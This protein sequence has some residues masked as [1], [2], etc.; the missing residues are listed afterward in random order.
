MKNGFFKKILLG[1]TCLLG[2]LTM[3]SCQSTSTS[4]AKFIKE[5]SNC[6]IIKVGSEG[7]T[8]HVRVSLAVVNNTIYDIK[9]GM[10]S[11]DVTH[12]SGESKTVETVGPYEVDSNF[13][14][15]HGGAGYIVDE[16]VPQDQ[17]KYLDVTNVV[18]SKA[19]VTKLTDVWET[20]MVW[21]ILM[22]VISGISLIS[23]SITIFAKGLSADD[24]A[25]I[26]KQHNASTMITLMFVLIICLFPLM[27]SGWMVTVILLGGFLADI[28]LAGALTAIRTKM[29]ANKT[30]K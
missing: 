15:P 8:I 9:G 1:A 29:L 16:L 19:E 12:G 11:F 28:I 21:W 2:V 25:K 22:I 7:T 13:Y 6:E 26:M 24:L 23:Y 27:F 18:F 4:E 17:E 5:Q 14:I 20:Y 10:F 30:P 3:A